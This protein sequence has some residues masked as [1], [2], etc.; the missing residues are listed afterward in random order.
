MYV[1]DVIDMSQALEEHVKVEVKMIKRLESMMEQTL[2]D[3]THAILLYMLS[4]ER[5]HHNTLITMLD[6]FRQS[7]IRIEEYLDLVEKYTYPGQNHGHKAH[8]F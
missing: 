7:E 8:R 3:R 1:G 6:L 4:D 2:D 5:R